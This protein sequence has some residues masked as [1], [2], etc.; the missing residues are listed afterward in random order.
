MVEVGTSN[1]YSTLWLADA[2]RASDGRLPSIDVDTSAQAEARSALGG[3]GL[4][5]VVRVRG[6]DGGQA[7]ASLPAGSVDAS[8]RVVGHHWRGG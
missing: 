8:R 3:C 4:D 5:H 7:L 2:L 6:G 1:G